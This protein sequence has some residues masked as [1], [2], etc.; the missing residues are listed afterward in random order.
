M[1]AAAPPVT[2]HAIAG[3]AAATEDGNSQAGGGVEKEV[4]GRGEHHEGGGYWV[5]PGQVAPP[6]AVLTVFRARRREACRSEVR[7]R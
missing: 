3:P 2:A 1:S 4:V 5:E 6:A 7:I